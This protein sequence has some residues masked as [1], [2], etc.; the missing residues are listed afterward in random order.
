ME[1]TTIMEAVR[2]GKDHGNNYPRTKRTSNRQGRQC[3]NAIREI[4]AKTRRKFLAE[5]KIRIVLEG[6]RKEMPI[7]DLCR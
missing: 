5:D 4:R 3:S 1:K 7:Y 6:F 2:K